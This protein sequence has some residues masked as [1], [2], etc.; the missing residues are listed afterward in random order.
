MTY[1]AY[2]LLT[3]SDIT[4]LKAAEEPRL[5]KPIKQAT[6]EAIITAYIGIEL[7]T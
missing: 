2:R 6:L 5:I 1:D 4:S 7:P 3:L